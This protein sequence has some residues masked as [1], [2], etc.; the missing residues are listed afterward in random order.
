MKAPL[1]PK[2][3]LVIG[4]QPVK[5]V[6][7]VHGP[8]V[9]RLL[10]EPRSKRNEGLYALASQ[11]GL[12]VE[13]A[14]RA[15]LDRLAHGGLHQGAVA[16]APALKLSPLGGLLESEDLLLLLDGVQDPQ[17]FGAVV[18]SAVGL[19]LCPV[20]W[21]ENSAAPLTPATFRASAGAIEHARLARV[22]SLRQAVF[23]ASSSGFMVVGLDAHAPGPLSELDL[24]GPVVLVLGSEGAGLSRAVKRSCHTLARL[25]LP[26]TIDS[27]NASVAAALA[28]YEVHGQRERKARSGQ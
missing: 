16:E 12:N 1:P 20:V 22:P 4:I 25:A 10:L 17:N 9:S 7:R 2:T 5:E 13:E 19:G 27:L 26:H 23:D 18:R 3:R 15:L 28:L 11:H 14:P 8:A 21:P 6:L 24:T